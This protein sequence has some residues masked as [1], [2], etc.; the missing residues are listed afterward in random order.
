[1]AKRQTNACHPPHRSLDCPALDDNG[2]FEIIYSRQSLSCFLHNQPV[3]PWGGPATVEQALRVQEICSWNKF[4]KYGSRN[5][6]RNHSHFLP[7]F[8]L[9]FC[10]RCT[11]SAN[12]FW[13]RFERFWNVRLPL[14]AGAG[15]LWA[16]G[17]DKSSSGL[18]RALLCSEYLG[19]PQLRTR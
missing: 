11:Y 10:S 4:V 7:N 1:M 9:Q 16:M 17:E 14:R 18:G 2:H 12:F 19:R 15:A 13:C 3:E 5:F 8:L 6:R